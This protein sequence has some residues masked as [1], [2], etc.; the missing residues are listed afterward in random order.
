VKRALLFAAVMLA[1]CNQPLF[2]TS[3]TSSSATGTGATGSLSSTTSAVSATATGDTGGTTGAGATTG[4]QTSGTGVTGG[5]ITSTGGT[6][7][8]G[9]TVG[10]TGM[11]GSS[12]IVFLG[13]RVPP[14][15]VFVVDRSV[16]MNAP[17]N[18]S[19]QDT[20]WDDVTFTVDDEL[21]ALGRSN[22]GDGGATKVALVTYPHPTT[23]APEGNNLCQPADLSM[24]LTPLV[25]ST[26]GSRDVPGAD[27]FS[28]ALGASAPFG[29]APVVSGL[30]KARALFDPY[31]DRYVVLIAAGAPDCD[32]DFADPP[33]ACVT[34]SGGC[35]D[36][37]ACF[38]A[39]GNA[40]SSDTP[41]GCTDTDLASSTLTTMSQGGIPT[42]VIG[43][44]ADMQDTNSTGHTALLNMAVAG[45]MVSSFAVATDQY[46]M[47]AALSGLDRALQTQCTIQ[48][49]AP[50]PADATS[51]MVQSGGSYGQLP[52][53]EWTPSGD[54]LSVKL[55]SPVCGTMAVDVPQQ[56]T[57]YN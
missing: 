41:L 12:M 19:S 27:A 7:S 29:H 2:E 21:F 51:M 6:T 8:L 30:T 13:Q 31:A 55:N 48:L 53:S 35:V 36:P 46:S 23:A 47:Q 43:V 56:I 22:V 4:G 28:S 44:G 42:L 11:S 40:E 15:I 52:R 54:G 45:G 49:A 24:P 16:G 38:D 9:S 32:Q 39:N 34:G 50:V 57:F 25:E 26:D 37:G 1:G 10:A 14:E 17:I 33:S 3:A 18:T 20:K 5:A